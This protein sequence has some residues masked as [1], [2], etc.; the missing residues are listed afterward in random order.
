MAQLQ[1]RV[2]MTIA[3]QQRLL[4][5]EGTYNARD[6]GGYPTRDG[7]ET[8]W[9]AIV[10]ADNLAQLTEAGR[11]SLVDYGVRRIIDL[12][13]PEELAMYPNPF[14]ATGTHG[15]EFINISMV[16]PAVTPPEV[17][18][19]LAND[20]K[21]IVDSFAPAIAEVM[22]SVAG[23]PEGTVLIHCHAGMDRTGII[24]AM[25]LDLAGVPEEIIA[26]DY[27][28]T[29]EL[30]RPVLE[31]WIENGPGERAWR[32]QERATHAPLAEVMREVLVHLHEKY[33]GTAEYLQRA[34]VTAS[35]IDRIRQRLTG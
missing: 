20:Y 2:S 8:R 13:K 4:A 26:A 6:L 27:A 33:G 14:A 18:T 10:R 7:G 5:W 15:V 25:L 17:F 12:R 11:R 28:L 34:G 21:R 29:G 19:T 23:A 9:G 24:S 16:D 3:E 32:E 30:L 35:E 1:G 22:R 31:E